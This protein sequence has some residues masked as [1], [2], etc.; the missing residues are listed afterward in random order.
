MFALLLL[1]FTA[2][3]PGTAKAEK[4]DVN[5]TVTEVETPARQIHDPAKGGHLIS[6][7][8]TRIVG[9]TMGILIYELIMKQG[10]S[11]PLHEHPYHTFYVL[12]GGTLAIYFV[13]MEKQILELPAG[14]GMIQP[15]SGDAAVNIGETTVLLLSHDIYALDPGE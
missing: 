11:V 14:F 10:D 8:V 2:C 1:S 3:K 15:P 4:N 13:D 5:Q 6:K 7:E 12:E 9:E